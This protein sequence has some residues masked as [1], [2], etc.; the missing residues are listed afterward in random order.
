[1][2]FK[3]SQ[4][5]L[6]AFLSAC[7]LEC[8]F[9]TWAIF[10]HQELDHSNHFLKCEIILFWLKS[11]SL[12][13]VDNFIE[14][15]LDRISEGDEVYSKPSFSRPAVRKSLFLSKHQSLTFKEG[16]LKYIH[17]STKSSAVYFT[18]NTLKIQ[19]LV[20]LGAFGWRSTFRPEFHC[21]S[22]FFFER[23]QIKSIFFLLLQMF[24]NI[25]FLCLSLRDCFCFVLTQYYDI[26]LHY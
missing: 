18:K 16:G 20:V 11:A 17:T 25:R 24:T 10:W 4:G 1:M 8:N 9:L 5:G 23:G 2:K 19:L 13:I 14:C 21:R 12:I 15:S 3:I 26:S 6:F 22:R 7:I